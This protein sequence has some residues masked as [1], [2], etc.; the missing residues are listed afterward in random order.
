MSDVMIGNHF[1]NIQSQ[2]EPVAEIS[3][4]EGGGTGT[5]IGAP[6]PP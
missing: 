6:V 4:P 3:T 1:F 2:I 5:P